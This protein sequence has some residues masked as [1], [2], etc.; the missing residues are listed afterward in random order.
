MF[1]EK[2]WV[3]GSKAEAEKMPWIERRGITLKNL[4]SPTALRNPCSRNHKRKKHLPICQHRRP[5][6]SISFS[7]SED[8]I[9]SAARISHRML[10]L[11]AL[12]V[13]KMAIR[14]LSQLVE[15]LSQKGSRKKKIV[16]KN[17]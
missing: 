8:S 1:L 4:E 3:K 2:T 13:Q 16:E 17:P 14:S 15:N 9:T 11:R 6:E 7:L 5:R 12:C 10:I